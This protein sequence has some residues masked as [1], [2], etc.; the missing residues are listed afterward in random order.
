MVSISG[1]GLRR[2]TQHLLEV[3]WQASGIPR[4]FSDVDPGAVRPGRAV[5]EKKRAG[6]FLAGSI[7]ATADWYFCWCHATGNLRIAEIDSHICDYRKRITTETSDCWAKGK[8]C[9]EN[10]GVALP[11]I[12]QP[13]S[14]S[15][16]NLGT[17]C[18]VPLGLL[19]IARW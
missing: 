2:S 14:S 4:S 17:F 6:R 1:C 9:V 12:S 16:Q 8:V 19:E 18:F 11:F 3:Y 10:C 5:L 15:T 7:V 13:E